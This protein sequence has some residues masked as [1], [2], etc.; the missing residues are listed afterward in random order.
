[1]ENAKE[2]VKLKILE[3]EGLN[4]QKYNDLQAEVNKLE[5]ENEAKNNTIDYLRNQV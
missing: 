5:Q 4:K 3:L 1:M 2:E